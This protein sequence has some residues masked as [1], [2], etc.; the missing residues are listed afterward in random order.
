ML[1]THMLSSQKLLV[2][3]IDDLVRRN[4]TF[5]QKLAQKSPEVVYGDGRE[6]TQDSEECRSFCRLLAAETIVLLKNSDNVLPL[7]PTKPKNQSIA[8]IGSHAKATIISG[9][10]SAALKPSYVVTPWEGILGHAD[11]AFEIHYS[12]GAHGSSNWQL[13]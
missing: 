5:I 8:V 1:V 7:L 9:G 12:L 4:L 11:S 13:S 3:D 6:R 2:S 10:G